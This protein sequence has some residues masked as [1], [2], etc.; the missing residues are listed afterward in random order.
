MN[1]E[2]KQIRMDILELKNAINR[3]NFVGHQ[4]FA[5]Y[6]DFTD[7]IKMPIYTTLPT[8]CRAGELVVVG[9]KLYVGVTTDTWGLV[10][11]QTA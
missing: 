6:S 1:D 4:E 5:K 10:G 11:G 8:K 3:N 7:R 2:L 9:G